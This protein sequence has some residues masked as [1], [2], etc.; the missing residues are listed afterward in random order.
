MTLPAE[1]RH[2]PRFEA[3]CRI[4]Y[5]VVDRARSEEGVCLNISAAGIE[6]KARRPIDIGKAVELSTLPDHPS[7]PSLTALVEVLRCEAG[8][9]SEYYIAAA[10]Q[11]LKAN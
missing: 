1:K 7:M 10:I 3:H 5:T 11:G 8:S 6:F 9:D 4:H 2:F